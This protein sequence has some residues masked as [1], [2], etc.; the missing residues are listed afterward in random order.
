MNSLPAPHEN[1]EKEFGDEAPAS[2]RLDSIGLP[3]K[4]NPLVKDEHKA[5]D[6]ASTSIIP[7]VSK[8][9]KEEPSFEIISQKQE[10]E[11]SPKMIIVTNEEEQV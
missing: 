8:K 6:E 5:D 2:S 7:V 11:N 3:E 10:D 1:D 4:M 9:E